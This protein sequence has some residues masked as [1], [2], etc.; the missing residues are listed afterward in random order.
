M[1]INARPGHH[2]FSPFYLPSF[3]IRLSRFISPCFCYF[4]L[5]I[6]LSLFACLSV[7]VSV[8]HPLPLSLSRHLT[9]F[10]SLSLTVIL[11]SSSPILRYPPL[12]VRQTPSLSPPI[13][14]PK[15]CEITVSLKPHEFVTNG[16]KPRCQGT[17]CGIVFGTA[18]AVSAPQALPSPHLFVMTLTPCSPAP[19]FPVSPSPPSLP[20]TV[21]LPRPSLQLWLCDTRQNPDNARECV[22]S[23]VEEARL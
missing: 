3:S 15:S 6:F 11:P 5:F 7:S 23:A 12:P 9:T 8:C 21:H 4:C 13:T 16:L 18:S 14:R 10:T 1:V 2:S 22:G 19:P 20:Q 17:C